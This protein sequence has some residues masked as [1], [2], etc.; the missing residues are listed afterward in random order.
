MTHNGITVYKKL[1]E[2]I[3]NKYF[4]TF[5]DDKSRKALWLFILRQK[6]N[7]YGGHNGFVTVYGLQRFPYI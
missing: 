5:L 1:L 3:G 6:I 4:T 2:S 7:R